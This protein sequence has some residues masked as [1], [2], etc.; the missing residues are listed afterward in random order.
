MMRFDRLKLYIWLGDFVWGV[1][2][3]GNLCYS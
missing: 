3:V 2:R 1:V